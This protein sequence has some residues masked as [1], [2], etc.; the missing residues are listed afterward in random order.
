MHD[1]IRSPTN[2]NDKRSALDK[3][4]PSRSG[5]GQ[6]LSGGVKSVAMLRWPLVVALTATATLTACATRQTAEPV[7]DVAA[8][9]RQVD[10]LI[11]AGCYR[12]LRDA[13]RALPSTG[14]LLDRRRFQVL[15]L[16]GVRVRELGLTGE[17]EWIGQARE[18]A[19]A[20]PSD[21]QLLLLDLAF[22]TTLPHGA[23]PP[24]SG[25][26]AERAAM[27]SLGERATRQLPLLALTDPVAAYFLR[28]AACMGMGGAP[29]AGQ[30]TD[31]MRRVPLVAY[32]IVTCGRIDEELDALLAAE[33]RF[34]ELHYFKAASAFVA[35]ALLTTEHELNQF[36]E[37]FPGAP[38]SAM[39]RGQVLLA[40]DEFEP[41][42]AAFD[43]V[44]ANHPD[45]PEALLYRMRAVSQLGDERQGE[46]AADRLV[47][48][49]TW[50]QGEAYYWRAWNRRAL[51]RLDEAAADVETAKRVLFN[52]AVPKLAGFIAYER[53][54]L[55]LALT[56]LS[57]S[58]ERNAE[59][60]E[61]QF[62]IGQ[63]H[64]R[65]AH[66]PDAAR[67]FTETIGC[68][69][70]AQTA[71]R[72][73][74]NEIAH[75]PLDQTRRLRFQARAERNLSTE[76]AREGIA[77]FSAATAYVLAGHADR[78]RPLAERAVS[79]ETL[80]VRARE[81]LAGLPARR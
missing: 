33:P 77:T 61:V 21:E 56:E 59:D 57:A 71:A 52:A 47:A 29:D 60:C 79:W 78:A 31:V 36:D 18:L 25:G 62:A 66:W 35:G 37:T 73:R 27:V 9:D 6:V 8:I 63:V 7:L 1:E 2:N 49:G 42:I 5:H 53:E 75:S 40:L 46:A 51:G 80:A 65:R 54:Q 24:M 11:R 39:L 13:L 74:M 58:R 4:R 50:Y 48:L 43:S 15:V 76:H 41:A 3:Q 28:H 20:S 45:Q 55:D 44:L 69:Q 14:S 72:N 64:V 16:L 38:A 81:L 19:G 67:S 23:G 30:V 26:A 12:C 70:A 68:A 22:A 17:P 34:Q 32:Q 10:G